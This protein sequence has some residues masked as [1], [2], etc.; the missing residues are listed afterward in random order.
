MY[1]YGENNNLFSS[2]LL[3]TSYTSLLIFCSVLHHSSVDGGGCTCIKYHFLRLDSIKLWSL[4][5]SAKW[6]RTH[7]SRASSKSLRWW[8]YL[9]FSWKWEAK[10]SKTNNSWLKN[11]YINTQHIQT[12][13][14]KWKFSQ[15]KHHT[16][17]HHPW[18][19]TGN[20]SN[21]VVSMVVS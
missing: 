13:R 14:W 19:I 9:I 4:L 2:S 6:K 7:I 8:I 10:N 1:V 11:L 17:G 15:N 18:R 16:I 3:S 5:I 21:L 20:G 12:C